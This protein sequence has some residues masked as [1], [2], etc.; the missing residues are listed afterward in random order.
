ME[1]EEKKVEV[2]KLY[3]EVIEQIDNTDLLEDEEKKKAI[4]EI[5]ALALDGKVTNY[6]S[7]S[8]GASKVRTLMVW[9]YTPS[10]HEF[11]DKVERA[12]NVS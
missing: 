3:Q 4:S 6:W 9:K 5:K 8:L 11:W 12:T 2:K 7:E 1:T 10:G